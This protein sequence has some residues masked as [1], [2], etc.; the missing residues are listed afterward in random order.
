M[1]NNYIKNRGI[2]KTII[3]NNNRNLVNQID[4]D[5]DYD[6]EI[7]NISIN[8]NDNGN[9]KEFN[10]TLDN[11]DLANILNI[12]SVDIPIDKRLKIDF[13]DS[14]YKPEKSLI[15]IPAPA[16]EYNIP[17]IYDKKSSHHI[18][19]PASSEELIIPVTI[20]R[21]TIDNLTFTPKRRHKRA[22]THITHKVYKKPKTTTK[23]KSSVRSQQGRRKSRRSTKKPSSLINLL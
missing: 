20:D 5:A 22:K 19:S 1:L 23:S 3:H 9:R 7:A 17:I 21:K 12:Q 4:W 6:G 11:D 15:E 2:T 14:Y 8:T 18:S 10:F 16:I 13:E